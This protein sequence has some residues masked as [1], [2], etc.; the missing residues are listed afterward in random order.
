MEVDFAVWL[1]G[2]VQFIEVKWNETG[3]DSKALKPM[4]QVREVM[5]DD[6][7]DRHLL[8]CRTP[9]AHWQSRWFAP[10][11]PSRHG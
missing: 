1:N 2:R 9:F 10:R 4:R 5:G 7:S 11:R 8:A 3:G 6:A